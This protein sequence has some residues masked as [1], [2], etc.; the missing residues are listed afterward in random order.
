MATTNPSQ[1]ELLDAYIVLEE[2]KKEISKI[3]PA[4]S[5]LSTSLEKR[6]IKYN[7]G[8]KLKLTNVISSSIQNIKNW[9]KE[10]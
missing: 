2:I 4:W 1:S 9:I 8:K 10:D 6:F 3:D 5:D 7:Y